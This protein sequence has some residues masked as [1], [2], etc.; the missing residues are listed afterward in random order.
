MSIAVSIVVPT[1]HRT[2]SLLRCLDALLSQ[3]F[4][5]ADYEIIVVDNAASEETRLAV[6][7]WVEDVITERCN[8]KKAYQIT[9]DDVL[10]EGRLYQNGALSAATLTQEMV[11][12]LPEI[13]VVRY[14]PANGKRGP[15][16]ARNRGWKAAV[17]NIIAFTDDDCI[18]D[19]EW[20]R[21][22]VQAIESGY[23]GVYGKV[24]VPLP[25]NPTDYEKDSAGLERSEF[26][27]ANCFYRR[28]LLEAVNGF[29]ERFTTAWREDSDL[30]FTLLEKEFNFIQVESALVFHPV[31][32]AKWGI[33]IDQQKKAMFNALL[34]KKHP[35]LYRKKIQSRPPW[36]YYLA[37]TGLT[38]AA[39]GLLVQSSGWFWWGFITW[40]L[41][42]V[43]FCMLRLQGTSHRF[44]HILEMLVTSVVIPPL[45]VYWRLR[46]A[47]QFKVFF[48]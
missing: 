30:Y 10:T 36:H 45:A 28:S 41:T 24:I 38:A 4:E 12:V 37:V 8:S 35:R 15:A 9:S 23:D 42:T 17:G 33:S 46:G 5:P 22:G 11:T 27:T 14:M 47:I 26:I 39:V 48:I 29:D 13:P 20:L 1:Y 7:A 19:P 31:R 32:P 25:K 2:Q 18:P 3:E 43:T 34:F 40:L 6:A 44:R 16:A 21:S